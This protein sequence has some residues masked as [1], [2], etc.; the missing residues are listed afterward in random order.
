MN[1]LVTGCLGTIGAPLVRKLIDKAN[2]ISIDNRHALGTIRCDITNFRKLE[3]IFEETVPDV[4]YHLAAEFGRKNGEEY[5]EDLWNTNVIGTRHIIELC[6]QFKSKLIFTSSS[7]VYGNFAIPQ[8]ETDT[9]GFAPDFNNDYAITKYVNELQILRF[10]K[11]HGLQ[12]VIL[13][14][15]NAYGPGEYYTDYRSVICLFLYKIMNN[16]EIIAYRNYH[17]VFMYIDDLINTLAKVYLCEDVFNGE[18]INIGGKQ[19]Y[20][21]EELIKIIENITKLKANVIWKTKEQANVVDKQPYLDKAFKLLK[22]DPSTPLEVGIA[23]TFNWMRKV[24]GL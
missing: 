12:A 22:H 4:V 13:R 8:R 5:Y 21:I 24:Y 18:I 17:R 15:F 23:N 7:E 16:E 10:I 6:L 14:L 11:L 19:M 3:R 20:S 2:V 9:N 1:I